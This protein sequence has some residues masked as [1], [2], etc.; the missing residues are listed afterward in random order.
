MTE[1]EKDISIDEHQLEFELLRQPKLFLK[2]SELSV[3]ANFIKDKAKEQLEVLKSE[4]D[5]EIRNDFAKFGF[6]AKPTEGA[7]KATI[8][9][10]EEYQ[11]AT[12]V[13]MQLTSTYNSLNGVK[14]ALDH[15]R[16]SL[17]L[18]VSLIIR[19]YSSEIKVPEEF[20]KKTQEK[21]H[22]GLNKKLSNNKRIK[23]QKKT[24]EV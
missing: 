13:C 11:K 21:A 20:T 14:L 1:Y 17:E 18:L 24:K 6:T 7:I 5:L 3:D 23:I 4:I 16:K 19:G 15:K 10:Q 2:Y 8:L 9:Q 22:K 12:D